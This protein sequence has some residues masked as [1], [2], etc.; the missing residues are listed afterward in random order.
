M[1]GSGIYGANVC[2]YNDAGVLINSTVTGISGSWECGILDDDVEGCRIVTKCGEECS[3][4]YQGE[5][6]D[7]LLDI[8][9]EGPDTDELIQIDGVFDD[10]NMD[11]IIQRNRINKKGF[12]IDTLYFK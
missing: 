12:P 10:T 5:V 8:I 6:A 3:Y 9:I 4:I 11:L 1:D 7:C 2:A